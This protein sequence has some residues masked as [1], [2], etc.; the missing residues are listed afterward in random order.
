VSASL[1]LPD[2][3]EIVLAITENHS[4]ICKFDK[5]D[6]T[7]ELVIE[8]IADLVQRATK[9]PASLSV[10]AI[11]LQDAQT[12]EKRR[13]VASFRTDDS[14]SEGNAPLLQP[15]VHYGMPTYSNSDLPSGETSGRQSL[16]TSVS[17]LSILPVI[18][19][20]YS[21]NPDFIGRDK[22]FDSVKS[23]L[24]SSTTGQKRVALYGLGGVG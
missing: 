3:I 14:L 8:N 5:Q 18:I 10:P 4:D 7:Y 23:I 9:P 13:S 21:E 1:G 22:I 16:E 17:S 2:S 11:F 12:N 24:Q 15:N 6:D 20:P 19:M